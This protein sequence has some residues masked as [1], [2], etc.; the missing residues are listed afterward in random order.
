[1]VIHYQETSFLSSPFSKSL[2]DLTV[3]CSAVRQQCKRGYG[4][5]LTPRAGLQLCGQKNSEQEEEPGVQCCAVLSCSVVSDSLQCHGLQP[6]RG[7]SRQK[8]WSEWPC[9]P[10]GD[11]PH[12]GIEPRPPS[13]QADSLPSEPLGKP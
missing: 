5:R 11:L 10:P 9:P 4:A 1:M 3:L 7:F 12:P 6:A 8:H 13:W 2:T